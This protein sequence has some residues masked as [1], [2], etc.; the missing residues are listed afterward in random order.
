MDEMN[1]GS[2]FV[3]RP[4]DN[5]INHNI[6][7]YGKP[8]RLGQIAM[9]LGLIAFF[10]AFTCMIYPAA[11]LGGVAIV[12]AVLSRGRGRRFDGTAKVGLWS[13]IAALIVN[14]A[15][16]AGVVALIFSNGEFKNMMN[17]ACREMYGQTFDDM[18]DDAMDGTFD[19]EYENLPYNLQ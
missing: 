7:R 19:L 14:V 16:I 8:N 3:E 13:G 4:S 17:E 9:I 10:I 11:M 6:N 15:I 2:P 18:V 1:Y 5:E 12:L